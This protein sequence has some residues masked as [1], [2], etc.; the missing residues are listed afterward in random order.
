[1]EKYNEILDRRK[2]K[3]KNKLMIRKFPPVFP[4]PTPILSIW[5]FF[6]NLILL[7]FSVISNLLIIPNRRPH[8]LQRPADANS[9]G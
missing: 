5:Y 4:Q 3:T 1:M 9:K 8:G 7:I 2:P 6:V